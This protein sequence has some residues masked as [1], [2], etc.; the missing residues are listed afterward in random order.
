MSGASHNSSG[1]ADA[2]KRGAVVVISGPSGVGKSTLCGRLC[3]RLPAEFS[4]SVTTRTI[5]PGEVDGQ[6]YRYISPADFD[7]VKSGGGLLESATVYGHSY[8]TP[9]EPVQ[10]A[11]A[12]RRVIILEIDINGCVQVREKYP[13]ALTFFVLPPNPEEQRRR[14][15]GRKTDVE[16]EIARRLAKADGEIRHARESGCYD[17]FLIN[18]NLDETTASIESIIR[19]ELS[20]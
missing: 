2:R 18:D 3:D 20:A 13:R 9:L 6:H 19:K 7:K 1:P 5:R 4:V 16:S 8:G 15:V 14:I 12:E 11:L 10:R 17:H